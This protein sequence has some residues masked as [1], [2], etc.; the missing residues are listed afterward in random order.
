[1]E[2]EIKKENVEFIV[3]ELK[4][5]D[6]LTI[7]KEHIF[8]KATEVEA[9]LNQVAETQEEAQLIAELLSVKYHHGY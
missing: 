5:G 7:P 1:M 3:I 9:C 8:I 4:S 2:K 6:V